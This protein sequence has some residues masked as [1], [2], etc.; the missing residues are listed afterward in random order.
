MAKTVDEIPLPCRRLGTRRTVTVHRY[1]R[2]GQN[3]RSKASGFCLHHGFLLV[4]S[5]SCVVTQL[6]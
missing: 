4:S 5:H 1:G 2:A 3:P 6:S